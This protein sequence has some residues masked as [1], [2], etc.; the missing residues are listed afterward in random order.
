M[1]RSKRERLLLPDE[2]VVSHCCIHDAF[3]IPALKSVRS[4]LNDYRPSS[5]V[6][7]KIC[8][9]SDRVLSVPQILT[10]KEELDGL[11]FILVNCDELEILVSSN[12]ARIQ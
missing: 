9:Y 6:N 7:Q 2:M 10:I 4:I 11:P 8:I 3:Y 1:Y 12:F 5:G